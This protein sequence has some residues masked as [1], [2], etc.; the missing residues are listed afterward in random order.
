MCQ[1]V[2]ASRRAHADEC[3]LMFLPPLS[4]SPGSPPPQETLQDQQVSL[5]QSS[6][7]LLLLPLVPGCMRFCVCPLRV[8]SLFPS[9]LRS[10]CVQVLQAFKAKSSSWCQTPGLEGLTW[11]S[12]LSLLCENLCNI[13]NLQFVGCPPRGYRI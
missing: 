4:M 12:E 8:K 11:G 3:F 2:P 1:G 9:I 5:G 13:I 6:I 10:F 7:K